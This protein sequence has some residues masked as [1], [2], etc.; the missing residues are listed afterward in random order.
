MRAVPEYDDSPASAKAA[1]GR[2]GMDA[3]NVVPAGLRAPE[4][5]P[6]RAEAPDR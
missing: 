2:G 4:S 3:I 1:A 5:R 6:S